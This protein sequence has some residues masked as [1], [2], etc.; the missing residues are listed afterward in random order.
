MPPI[1]TAGILQHPPDFS[2]V[3]G[4]PLFQMFRRAHLSGPALELLRRRVLVIS[5][6][7]WLPLAL[8]SAL[9]GHLLGGRNLSFLRDLESH[10]RFLVALP[11]LIHVHSPSFPRQA[12][13]LD[14][15]QNAGHCLRCRL[16]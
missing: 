4:G 11:V 10:V 3:L 15:I 2:L 5:L 1:P 6:V 7:A 16:R 14:R 8:L 12:Q 9:E 13:G